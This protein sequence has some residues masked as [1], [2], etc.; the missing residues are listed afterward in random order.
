M[1]FLKIQDGGCLGTLSF[2]ISET[3]HLIKKLITDITDIS[4]V[5]INTPIKNT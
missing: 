1:D 5:L 4:K 3:K 2:T